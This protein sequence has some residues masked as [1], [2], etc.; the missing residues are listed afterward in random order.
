[1]LS[2]YTTAI[3]CNLF[4]AAKER[5]FP[6]WITICVIGVAYVLATQIDDRLKASSSAWIGFVCASLGGFI[7][8][9]FITIDFNNAPLNLFSFQVS[10]IVMMIA[11]IH[12]ENAVQKP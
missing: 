10:L 2:G 8:I 11:Y 9:S 5:S 7:A 12:Y 6:L 3:Y 1:M 4:L